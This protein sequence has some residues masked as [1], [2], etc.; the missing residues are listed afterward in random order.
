MEFVSRIYGMAFADEVTTFFTYV[1]LGWLVIGTLMVL[2][3]PVARSAF[4]AKF[5]AMTPT[6]LATLGIL[7]TF[8]GILLGLQDFDVNR[9]DESVPQLLAGLK[10]AFVTS[11]VGIVAA[12]AFRLIR[13]IVPS[14]GT[15]QGVSPEDIL[16]ALLEIRD[17][18][19]RAS[20]RSDD[21]LTELRKAISSEGDSNLLTQIQKLRTTVQDGQ[22][23]YIRE[24]R[25]FAKHMTENS[26]RALIEALEQVIRDFNT[27]LTEQFGENFK[28][29]NAA[30]HALVVWQD[31]YR[32]H[33]EALGKRLEIAVTAVEASQKA[34]ESVRSHSERIPEM[35]K[36][37]EPILTG[38]NAQ[39]MLLGGHLEAVA[40]LRDKAVEAFPVIE[41]NLQ[42]VTTQFAQSVEEAVM[43]S[44]KA[45][46]EGQQAHAELRK[47]YDA[48]LAD[49]GTARERF[50]N[51]LATA[52]KQMS[53]K[54]AQEFARHGE[55][56]E[57]NAKEAQ[58]AIG[59]SWSKSVEKL[60]RALELLGRNLASV[61]EKLVGDYSVLTQKLRDFVAATRSAV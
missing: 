35:I 41:A 15:A 31:Q 12:V 58:K 33:V 40:A 60:T 49:A 46:A 11:I 38:I 2:V 4:G 55:L 51:E 39:T 61:S 26:Q 5:I 56:I 29:L 20:Q 19:R 18:G 7:G 43:T 52:L 50:S 53:E 24:F 10:T 32:Q 45:L 42:K 28:Q 22:A 25:D 48:F 3:L 44:R 21:Q 23:E 36:P 47:G 57:A 8:T 9:V 59:E 27:K 14:G 17:D 1:T 30:V 34:L 37:L 16:A 54:S 13:T 6:T